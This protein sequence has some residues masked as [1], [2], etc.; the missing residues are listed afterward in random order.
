MTV[1]EPLNADPNN[2]IELANLNHWG[3]PKPLIPEEMKP[4]EFPVGA[5]GAMKP[6]IE[7]IA[8]ATKAPKAL[9]AASVLSVANFAAAASYDVEL[10]GRRIRPIS[11]III[12]R[13]ESGER[14]SAVDA[15]ATR[16]IER[17]QEAQMRSYRVACA[18]FD[19]GAI[20][21]HPGPIP[22]IRLS[23]GTFPGIEKAFE[24]GPSALYLCSD[25]AGRILGGH[26]LKTENKVATFAALSELWDGTA[27][28]R[29]YRGNDKS[30]A[31]ISY[32]KDC[33]LCVHLLAQPS[34]L[35]PLLADTVAQGQGIFAR[36]LL[37]SPRSNI[38]HRFMTV[39]EYTQLTSTGAADVFA[40]KIEDMLRS[41]PD[42]DVSSHDVQRKVMRL[43]EAAIFVMV[44]YV[45]E[46]ER[47][48]ADGARF[49]EARAFVNKSPEQAARI[50]AT[51][52]AFEECDQISEIQMSSAV[53]IARYFMVESVRLLD[54]V[55][56]E[57][58]LK[59]ALTIAKYVDDFANRERRFPTKREVERGPR[60]AKDKSRRL[61]A[62]Q[63]LIDFG[64]LKHM[65]GA[66]HLNPNLKSLGLL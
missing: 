23:N 41:K 30:R 13:G 54:H 26:S 6:A 19:A 14:K 1:R 58:S 18:E 39:E 31:E 59:D 9:V 17:F 2:S 22:I 56:D 55:V 36:A 4:I 37:H 15:R 7:D 47:L 50:A 63:I 11:M 43:S 40:A 21:Q 42:R 34:I 24:Q 62:F 60:A 52:A 25:E 29:I 28:S 46:V 49:S 66:C 3:T 64:W 61:P 65:N 20:S 32:I 53:K 35:K 44:N 5:M 48:M 8:N 51:I 10:F 12:T 45:N 27:I 33:R 38:G 57:S 16:G